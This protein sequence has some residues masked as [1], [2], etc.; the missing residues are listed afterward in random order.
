MSWWERREHV[1][2]GF[3]QGLFRHPKRIKLDPECVITKIELAEDREEPGPRD[4][5]LGVSKLLQKPFGEARTFRENFAASDSVF[6]LKAKSL[7]EE[8]IK[9]SSSQLPRKL[10]KQ[11]LDSLNESSFSNLFGTPA[12]S[13]EKMGNWFTKE[14][15]KSS[16][17]RNLDE[18]REITSAV[19]VPDRS[20]IVPYDDSFVSQ[21]EEATEE[22]DISFLDDLKLPRRSPVRSIEVQPVPVPEEAFHRGLDNS[23]LK[24][25]EQRRVKDEERKKIDDE[26]QRNK[27]LDLRKQVIEIENERNK[28]TIAEATGDRLRL[29]L[30]G[31]ILD[32]PKEKPDSFP[33]LPEKAVELVRNAWNRRLPLDEIFADSGTVKITRKDLL[34]LSG[35]DWLNDEIINFYLNLVCKRAEL[36]SD[37]PSV[38]AFQTFFYTTLSQ[39]GYPGVKRWTRKVDVFAYDVWLIPVH[40][41]VHWCMAIVDLKNKTIEYYDSMLGGNP[42]AFQIISDYIVSESN[43]KKKQEMDLSEWKLIERRDI[44]TQQNGSDCGMFSCKFA[45]YGSRKAEIDFSQKNMPYYRQR[46]VYEICRQELM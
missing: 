43:D 18:L 30:E 4:S 14:K 1:D 33:P 46:M 2:S 44:P 7:Y 37:L 6:D 29:E 21:A 32:I 38:Y 28:K 20:R 27:I 11:K 10:P 40:L 19:Q 15:P 42:H 45:E 22:L 39:R 34:T 36:D 24:E 12:K 16:F 41:Q 9:R 26:R 5:S 17:E 8:L 3:S 13:K 31:L 23:K 35:L 25:I